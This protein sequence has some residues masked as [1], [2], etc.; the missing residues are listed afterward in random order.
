MTLEQI[1]KIMWNLFGSLI[2]LCVGIG[3]IF[4]TVLGY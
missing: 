3:A 1:K 4:H 2:Y